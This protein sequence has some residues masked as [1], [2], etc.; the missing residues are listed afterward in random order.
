MRYSFLQS[1]IERL[2]SLGE[3]TELEISIEESNFKGIVQIGYSKS[4]AKEIKDYFKYLSRNNGIDGTYITFPDE[5]YEIFVEKARYNSIIETLGYSWWDK[6][7]N[8]YATFNGKEKAEGKPNY[9]NR[10]NFVIRKNDE[11]FS[12]TVYCNTNDAE[13]ALSVVIDYCKKNTGGT[14]GVGSLS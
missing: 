7:G 13:K 1:E 11:Q 14:Q 6:T 5:T 3:N 2:E 12:F 9:R 8:L 4:S 10:F